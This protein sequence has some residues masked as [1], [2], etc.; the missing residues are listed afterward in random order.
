MDKPSIIKERYKNSFENFLGVVFNAYADGY[1]EIQLEIK[2]E[3]LNIG[4]TVH[5]G[6]INALAD[7]ALSGAVTS[8]FKE[9]AESVVTMQM[10]VY[11]IKAGKKDDLLTAY[12]QVLK[13]GR[14]IC[15]VEGGLKN[16]E[17]Q[18]IAKADGTWFIKK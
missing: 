11:F 1:C 8:N 5:G 7:I 10:N 15:Y 16:R 18:L 12:G 4:D 2:P 14:S 6:I 9:K 13:L 3:H 17:G